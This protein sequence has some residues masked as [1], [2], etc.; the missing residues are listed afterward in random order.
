[1][2]LP[3]WGPPKIEVSVLKRDEGVLQL[4]VPKLTNALTKMMLQSQSLVQQANAP[5]PQSSM[6]QHQFFGQNQAF[7]QLSPQ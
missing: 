2:N 3:A 7:S 1:M 5:I 4:I 6:I